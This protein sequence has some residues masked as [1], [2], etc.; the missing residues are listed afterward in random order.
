MKEIQFTG[1][2]SSVREA[3]LNK[4]PVHE[5]DWLQ[6]DMDP[7]GESVGRLRE[8]IHEVDEH[9]GFNVRFNGRSELGLEHLL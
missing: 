4:L 7:T 3:V 2:S 8:A 5:G 6:I 1:V 9:L